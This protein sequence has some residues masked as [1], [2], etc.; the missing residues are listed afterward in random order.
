LLSAAEGAW[1]EGWTEGRERRREGGRGRERE[2]RREE[3][4]EGV[5]MRIS[6]AAVSLFPR[7]KT[8]GVSDGGLNHPQCS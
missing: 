2:G 1:E 5:G 3:R 4:R 6:D 7:T 8:P